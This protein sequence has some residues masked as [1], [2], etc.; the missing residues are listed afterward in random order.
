MGTRG[1]KVYRYKGRY[2]VYYN[3]CD[4]YPDVFGLKV[5]HEIPRNLSKE[6]FEEW[7]RKTREYVYAQRDSKVL[8]DPGDR[9]SY[10]S[11]KLPENDI[12]KFIVWMYEIDL[13]NLVFHVNSQPFFRL[14]N[15]PPD[16]IFLKSI[17]YDH[18]G[19]HAL[20]EH[21]PAQFRYDWRAPP[22]SPLPESLVAYDR[23]NNRSSTN[24]VHDLLSIPVAKSS[25]ELVRTALVVVRVT[26][27]MVE[28]V[29]GHDVPVLENVPDRDHIPQNML[30]LAL[31]LVNFAVGPPI[32]SLPCTQYG[33][34]CDF[35]W[36][37]KDLC[38]R[39]TT[40]LDDEDNLRASIG[41][42]VHHINT[43]PDKVGTVHGISCSIFHCAIIRVDK[44]K[45]GTSF[46]HT[47]SLQFLPSFYARTMFTPGIEA[48]SR[49][50]CQAIGVEFLNAISDA[51]N[52]PRFTHQELLVTGPGPVAAKVP[53]E[54]WTTIGDLITSPADLVTLAS[55]SARAMSAAADL[56][57]FPLVDEF[58]LVEVVASGPVPPIPETTESTD[59]QDIRF[60]FGKMGCAKFTA[61]TGGRRINV[62]LVQSFGKRSFEV[63]TYLT[64]PVAISHNNL[65]LYISELDDDKAS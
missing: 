28:S 2:Y 48:L 62:E 22:P 35:V 11:D 1:N 31:S 30:Q 64:G 65:K 54:V 41:D 32:P 50:G 27:C 46:S 4:S 16:D 45:L 3:H 51:N 10:V 8:N 57:R 14:D 18:F 26:T 60:Y 20:Y 56:T 17:S 33:N 49:L 15:I 59:E 42:L 55:I 36:I 39:I 61:V 38:L 47:P 52:F 58:R 25:I 21:T 53:A 13:D 12:F 43:T 7:V 24:S 5:L 34:I 63:Q 37:R 9:S 44:D 23:Y 29:V 40:H 6:E 19:H